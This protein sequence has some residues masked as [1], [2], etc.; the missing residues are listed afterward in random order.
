MP[1]EPTSFFELP[2]LFY[3]AAI[4]IFVAGLME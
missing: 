3:V 1:P 4:V 2:T